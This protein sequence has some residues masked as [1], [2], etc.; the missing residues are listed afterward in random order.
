MKHIYISRCYSL[1]LTTLLFGSPFLSAAD[2]VTKV[3]ESALMQDE[4]RQTDVYIFLY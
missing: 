1:L 3:G 2:D 4:T